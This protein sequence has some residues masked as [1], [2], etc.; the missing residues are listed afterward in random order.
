MQFCSL[1]KQGLVLVLNCVGTVETQ[2]YSTLGPVLDMKFH[3]P[4]HFFS[5]YLLSTYY[6]PSTVLNAANRVEEGSISVLTLLPVQWIK[7]II[8]YTTHINPSCQFPLYPSNFLAF[9]KTFPPH[10]RMPSHSPQLKY[11]Q[12]SRSR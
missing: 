11:Y 4:L 7:Q 1:L 3:A 5:Q 6:V 10:L 12:F 9:I 8:W 2:S